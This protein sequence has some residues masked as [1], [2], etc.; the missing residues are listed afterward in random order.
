M[1]CIQKG[2]L[3]YMSVLFVPLQWQC[4]ER[5]CYSPDSCSMWWQGWGGHGDAQVC[6]PI[7]QLTYKIPSGG[8]YWTT[9]HFQ[10]KGQLVYT[11]HSFHIFYSV[12]IIFIEFRYINLHFQSLRRVNHDDSCKNLHC[13]YILYYD[14]H[15]CLYWSTSFWFRKHF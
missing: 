4:E 2:D 15:C 7:H 11:I 14:F 3:S 5:H 9:Q 13:R 12:L 1:I 8:G 6:S 10:I